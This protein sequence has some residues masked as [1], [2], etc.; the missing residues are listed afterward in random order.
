M[1]GKQP[2]KGLENDNRTRT[3]KRGGGG[4]KLL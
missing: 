4:G 3:S 1:A 2:V